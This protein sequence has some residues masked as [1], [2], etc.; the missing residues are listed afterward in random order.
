[1]KIKGFL[2]KKGI[3]CLKDYGPKELLIRMTEKLH[4]DAVPYDAWYQ[5]HRCTEKQLDEQRT[6]VNGWEE[7]P[8]ISICV[9]LYKTPEKYFCE[10]IES[11]QGQSYTNWQLCLADGSPTNSLEKVLQEKYGEEKRIKYQF[12]EKNL[13]IADN[14]N[15][16]FALAEGAWITLLD[17]DDVLAPEALY[18][19]IASAKLNTTQEADVVYSDEDKITEDLQKHFGPHFK[20]DYNLDLLRSN[21]YI[22]HLFAVKKEI[23]ECVGGFRKD[24]DGSQDHDFILRCTDVAKKIVHV[25]QI[26]YHWRT[27]ENS[28]AENPAS[29]MY[30]FDA[31]KRAVEAHLAA[32]GIKGEVTH[33][34]SLGFYRVKYEVQGT[35]MISIIVCGKKCPKKM[36]KSTYK[37]YEILYT[38][39]KVTS[40]NQ[41]MKT[42]TKGDYIILIAEEAKILEPNW[43]EELLGHCQRRE[44]AVAG[45]KILK[46]NGRVLSAGQVIGGASLINDL[47]YDTPGEYYGYFHLASLQTA[48]SAVSGNCLMLKKSVFEKVDGLGEEY[49]E[50]STAI[51]D[52]CLKVQKNDYKVVYTPYACVK[53]CVTDTSRA[54]NKSDKEKLLEKWEELKQPDPN[55]NPNLILEPAKYALKI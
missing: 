20:P 22:T 24:F 29:K 49:E 46:K 21:N 6:I 17:H 40:I 50:F 30:A 3:Q 48:Y 2:I 32:H 33:T 1:M 13:G 4:Q 5:E 18:E 52:Y 37:N 19:I 38:D 8:L 42:M 41:C 16:A 43:M 39:N 25:P 28:T 10:M 11:V 54:I 53:M 34:R 15:A 9:P 7:C 35:P 31:G 27:S 51:L 14:T 44:V 55:Y 23:V 45:T 26:L 12:L 47:F 36:E